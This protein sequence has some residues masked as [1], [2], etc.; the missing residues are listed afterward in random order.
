VIG[1]G[2]K[3]PSP[4]PS[5]LLEGLSSEGSELIANV[6]ETFWIRSDMTAV[7]QRLF[8]QV[9]AELEGC[10]DFTGRVRAHFEHLVVLLIKFLTDR[11]DGE[12]KRFPYLRRF[13]KNIDAPKEDA[14]QRDL[15]N[16]LLS[17][18]S[19][20]VEKTD[21]SS[22]RADIYIPRQDFRLIIELKRT[23]TWSESELNPFL[24]QTVAYS[25]TDVRLGVLDLSDRQPGMPHL[26][27]CFEV[28][29]REVTAEADRTALVMRVP[30]NTK[31]PSDSKEANA[32]ATE[33]QTE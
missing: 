3:G 30:G 21:I 2:A 15:H 13:K 31:T 4:T 7:Q 12:N 25:Q 29:R 6:G 16:F 22:G 8:K 17:V 24:T 20:Q 28:V 5:V 1:G 10:D 23:F 11:V 26:D 18:I 14:L 9:V 27:Q 19:A 32:S 33:D